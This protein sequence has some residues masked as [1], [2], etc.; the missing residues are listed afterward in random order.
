MLFSKKVF[1]EVQPMGGVGWRP[2]GRPWLLE[3]SRRRRGR[4][5]VMR[6]TILAKLILQVIF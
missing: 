1:H 3:S 5:L 4:K 6:V 2:S